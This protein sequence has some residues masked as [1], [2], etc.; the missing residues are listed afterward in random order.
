MMTD[1]EKEFWQLEEAHQELSRERDE[2]WLEL[3][4]DEEAE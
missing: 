4:E 2:L 1:W 3:H